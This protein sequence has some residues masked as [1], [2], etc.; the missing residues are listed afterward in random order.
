MN[1]SAQSSIEVNNRHKYDNKFGDLI[2][3]L[4]IMVDFVRSKKKADTSSKWCRNRMLS[5][6]NCANCLHILSQLLVMLDTFHL[7]T[8]A[9]SKLVHSCAN[10]VGMR[11]RESVEE[12]RRRVVSRHDVMKRRRVEILDTNYNEKVQREAETK[13]FT[14]SLSSAEGG[15]LDTI[16]SEEE[17]DAVTGS[18][19]RI[20]IHDL[21][22]LLEAS[23]TPDCELLLAFLL[24]MVYYPNVAI[25]TR[26]WAEGREMK[27]SNGI[28]PAN[29]WTFLVNGERGEG[30]MD[31]FLYPTRWSK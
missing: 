31:V 19:R 24:G 1:R 3:N 14:P 20:D 10:R 16:E 2:E 23:S 27:N 30:V 17:D 15:E 8:L 13:A 28:R 6:P 9:S 4:N 12:R 22:R 21:S 29:E 5:Y 25:A 26:T 18:N 7:T 11:G